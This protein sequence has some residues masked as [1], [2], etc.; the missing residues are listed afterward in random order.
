MKESGD[1]IRS[2]TVGGSGVADKS[3]ER[4]SV[5]GERR[6][7]EEDVVSEWKERIGRIG[8]GPKFLAR[9]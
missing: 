6:P 4:I 9:L 7:I 1:F 5:K 3:F 8:G 2:V